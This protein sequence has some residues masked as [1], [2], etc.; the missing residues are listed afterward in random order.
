[1]R[2]PYDSGTVHMLKVWKM[3]I[4]GTLFA[5]TAF[6]LLLST[7]PLWGQ[8]D[9]PLGN[10]KK[11]FSFAV[12]NKNSENFEEA[13]LQYEKS[14]SFCDT[15]YQVHYSYGDMLLKLEETARAKKAF[16]RARL[17]SPGH[18]DSAL[19][20]SKIYYAESSYDSVLVM[21]ENMYALRPD[22]TTVL[23]GIAG[24]KDYLG[25]NGE[26]LDAYGQLIEAG[27]DSFE[28][29]MSAA[30]I[31]RKLL[32][33]PVSRTYADAALEKQPGNSEALMIAAQASLDLGERMTAAGYLRTLAD[34]TPD[35]NVIIELE[36]IYRGEADHGNLIRTLEE[37][38][39]LAPDNVGVIG[40]LS[41]LLYARGE[42]ERAISYAEKGCALDGDDGRFH[43]ILGQNF[44]DLGQ[45]DKALAEFRKAM[46]DATWS[47][48]ARRFILQIEQ[49]E[50]AEEKAE[51]EFFRRGETR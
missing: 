41:E 42:T 36:H 14:L 45:R 27:E 35:L 47:A 38:H 13:V 3:S 23:S 33:Y 37:H 2:R 18:Y 31:A 49:P 40:E 19:M 50:T 7:R 32:D 28:N 17:L 8:D 51:R 30:R 5:A 6:L 15:L 39:Q 22:N 24:L 25:R 46:R 16:L 4:R 26:A 34:A 12:Q 1:M 20:L 29:L 11:H 44:L 48:S 9:T 43:I 21:Y 10:A